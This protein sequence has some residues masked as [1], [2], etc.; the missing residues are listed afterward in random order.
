MVHFSRV[1]KADVRLP[2]V[3]RLVRR[4]GNGRTARF[5]CGGPEEHSVFGG[6]HCEA[7]QRQMAA[8][9]QLDLFSVS[10]GPDG[11]NSPDCSTGPVIACNTLDDDRLLAA[12]LNAGIR[13]TVALVA[14]A[15]R[16]RLAA[17]IPVL[18]ALCRRFTGYGADRIVPE[19][20]A[21]LGAIALIG[22]RDA[23][24]T[25]VRLIAMRIVQGP[26][27]RQAVAAAARLGAKLPAGT[28]LELLRHDDPQ[29]R[30]DACRC[31][32]IW[33]EAVPL[34]R[35]LL[36]DLHSDARKAAAC[37]L[38]RMGRNE[39]RGLLVR[40][41]REE[42]TAELVDAI[43]CVAD[44]ECAVL[45]GR[46]ARAVPHLSEA[47]FDALHSIDHLGARAIAAALSADR[48]A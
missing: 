24:Q 20:A 32:R 36:D 45:L 38:A 33:P 12:T 21:A 43:A 19:Q 48:P 46:L 41:L 28:V 15:G 6:H 11:R 13:D 8:A 18:D 5:P 26:C 25:L 17:A 9:E 34:L 35:D 37:A 7:F 39:V 23:A 10:P 30:A 27:L 31:T 44:E 42:P 40:Y 22:G 3:C 47:A 29:I 16:R 4:G 14:E 2:S 1:R